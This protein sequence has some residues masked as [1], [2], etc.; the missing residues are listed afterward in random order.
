MWTHPR[1]AI[2]SERPRR[3]ADGWWT[4]SVHQRPMRNQLSGCVPLSSSGRL[5]GGF[6]NIPPTYTRVAQ[7]RL[8]RVIW[9]GALDD[10]ASGGIR[11][12]ALLVLAAL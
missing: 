1:P 10:T 12:Q 5:S 4:A 6:D 9:Q 3:G 7:Q 11:G 2:G 8:V